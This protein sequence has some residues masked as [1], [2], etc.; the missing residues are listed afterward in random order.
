MGKRIDLNAAR[1]ARAE[2]RGDESSVIVIGDNEY[3]LPPEMPVSLLEAFG[4]AQSGDAS[5]FT[6]GVIALLGSEEIYRTLLDEHVLTMEDLLEVME[7][8]MAAYGVTPGESK[9][10]SSSS[11]STTSPSNPT[12]SA[13]SAPTSETPSTA[14]A[15]A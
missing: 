4:R 3:P 7:G 12:S 2:A 11:P 6:D 9:G 15:I 10:S 13:T 8:A 1:A 14:P 5:G